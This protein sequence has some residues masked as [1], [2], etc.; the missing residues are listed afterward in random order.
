MSPPELFEIEEGHRDENVLWVGANVRARSVV[1][2]SRVY[3]VSVI[4][5]QRNESLTEF[6]EPQAAIF[7]FVVPV[8]E[9]LDLILRRNH[10]QL[11]DEAV[12]E[13]G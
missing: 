8:E 11:I 12:V 4:L 9:Q 2:L 10:A 7:I 6:S 3:H 1:L 5:V 13:L